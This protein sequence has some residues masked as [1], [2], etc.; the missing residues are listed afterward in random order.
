MTARIEWRPDGKI[1]PLMYWTPDG[2]R[3]EIKREY[4]MT[5]LAFLED[6]GE[7]LRY[8]IRAEA[9]ET[10]EPYA[11]RQFV[12]QETYLYLADDW[13]CGKNFIDG[14]YAHEGKEYIPVT[15]DIFPDRDYELVYFRVKGTRYAVEKTVSIE[16]RGS[17]YAGGV[18]IRHEVE[19]RQIRADNDED[20]DPSKS[21][22][23]VAALFFEVNKWFVNVRH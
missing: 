9:V 4:E 23:R 10:P 11:G 22:R 7:G 1:E 2:S 8:K 13:F 18:G 16:P 12:R 5:P 15:L 14:R 17:F 20:P 3:Y 19:A 6:R 21:V